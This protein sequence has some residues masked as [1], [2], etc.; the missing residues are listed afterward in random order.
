MEVRLADLVAAGVYADEKA[1]VEG[2]LH[3]LWQERP[4][5]R[6]E[7]AIHR[8]RAG[9][10]SVAKAAALAGVSFDRMKELLDQRDVPLRLGPETLDE[11]RAEADALQRMRP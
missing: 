9:G 4:A 2:A 7:V 11:A 3:V 6:V 5:V 8:Y 10:L 1:A